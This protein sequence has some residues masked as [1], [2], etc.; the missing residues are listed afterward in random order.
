MFETLSSALALTMSDIITLTLI[1]FA[2]GLVRGFSGFALSAVA[3][4]SAASFIPLV[5][6]IPLSLWLEIAASALLIRGNWHNVQKKNVLRLSIGTLIGLPLGLVLT[7]KVAVELSQNIALLLIMVLATLLLMGLRLEA[8]QRPLGTVFAGSG[9]GLG[10]GLASVGGILV[11]IFMLS[12]KR[13]ARNHA[14]NGYLIFAAQQRPQ[15]GKLF[16]I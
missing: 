4:A 13:L 7:T 11:A 12:F 9:A 5:E 3:M 8:L 14:R 2:A 10:K 1:C 15:R 16:F 6:L